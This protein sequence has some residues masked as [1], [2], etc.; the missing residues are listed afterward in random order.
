MAGKGGRVRTRTILLIAHACL[1]SEVLLV[2]G[3]FLASR[4]EV[5]DV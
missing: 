5:I 1:A 4:V 3:F 2:L